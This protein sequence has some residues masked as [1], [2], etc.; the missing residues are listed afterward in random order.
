MKGKKMTSEL[1]RR[2]LNYLRKKKWKANTKGMDRMDLVTIC[3]E[4]TTIIITSKNMTIINNSDG[5]VELTRNELV[6]I[7]DIMDGCRYEYKRIEANK[8]F[9]INK[10][11]PKG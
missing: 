4:N 9:G 10:F 6:K 8:R 7:V 11:R 3:N 5:N 1:I 2:A